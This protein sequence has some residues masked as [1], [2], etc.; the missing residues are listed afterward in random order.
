MFLVRLFCTSF[1]LPFFLRH[2]RKPSLRRRKARVVGPTLPST[3]FPTAPIENLDLA[4]LSAPVDTS[5]T[6]FKE[7]VKLWSSGTKEIRDV[8]S[9]EFGP[10][11]ECR[12]CRALFRSVA[13]ALLHKRHFCT[14]KWIDRSLDERE[15]E[16]VRITES[17]NRIA[18]AK[19]CEMLF[20]LPS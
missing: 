2:E 13:N 10:I 16:E 19:A 14:Q 12:L 5:V 17:A 3:V 4:E 20:R 6:G 9:D 8:L 1:V 15:R 11:L 18:A 7:I